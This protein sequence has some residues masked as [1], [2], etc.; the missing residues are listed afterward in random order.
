MQ[1]RLQEFPIILYDFK[2]AS[3]NAVFIN[4]SK[5]VIVSDLVEEFIVGNVESKSRK[6]NYHTVA[7]Q[8]N[9]RD[10]KDGY[11]TCEG[12]KF[13]GQPCYHTQ[14]LRNVTERNWKT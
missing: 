3:R 7:V 13:Y 1:K 9:G 6:G 4:S 8:L 5:N 12:L 10:I 14:T 2:E 11:C